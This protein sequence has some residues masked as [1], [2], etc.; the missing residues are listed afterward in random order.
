METIDFGPSTTTMRDLVASVRDDQLGWAT[1]C[2][3]YSVGDLVEHIGGLAVAFTGA[4]RKEPVPGSE[5]GGV[6]DAARLGPAWRE[7][8]DADLVALA[9]AWRDAGAYGGTTMAGPIEMPAPEAA[10]VALD[11]LV[12]HGWDLATALDLPFTARPEDVATCLGFAESFSTP[13]AAEVRG[14]AFGE[15]LEVPADAPPLT[16]LL[17][18]LGRRG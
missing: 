10:A 5:D 6:G 8:I 12:V 11:E 17:A 9:D 18:L 1:P 16:R 13:E 2:A 3:S 4:A 14:D 15:V 7:R